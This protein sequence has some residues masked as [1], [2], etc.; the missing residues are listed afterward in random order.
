M[1]TQDLRDNERSRDKY[2]THR[3]GWLKRWR[4]E[5]HVARKGILDDI[6][7][8]MVTLGGEDECGV[9]ISVGLFGAGLYLTFN[10]ILP[11]K[12]AIGWYSRDVFYKDGT[13][14]VIKNPRWHEDSHGKQWGFYFNN[15]CLHF[16]WGSTVA[17]SGGRGNSEHEKYGYSWHFWT[18]WTYGGSVRWD[19]QKEDGSFGMV[20]HEQANQARRARRAADKKNG[21]N[22][23]S[24]E[25][26]LSFKNENYPDGR[27]VY[28]EPYTYT[29]K[30]GEVQ[31]RIATF[32]VQE[33]EWRWNL[34]SKLPFRFGPKK[35]CRSISVEFD[36][37]LGE[38]CGSWKGGTYG[39]G[40][41]L[42][43]GEDPVACL[44]RMERERKFGR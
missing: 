40:Y 38:G 27:K 33:M 42:L 10:N 5:Y 35:V 18:F 28:V 43:P 34:F 11:K 15:E 6:A 24:I 21:C 16:A 20:D 13:G 9:A 31:N 7:R 29:L 39:C 26:H 37:G 36:T 23:M 4:W 19:V 22:E 30:S 8:F 41:D 1:H 2:F 12:W 14:E 32:H 3:R 17:S 25:D 44:R